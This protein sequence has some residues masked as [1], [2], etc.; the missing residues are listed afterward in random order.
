[1]PGLYRMLQ[2]LV[3]AAFVA[4]SARPLSFFQAAIEI[5]AARTIRITFMKWVASVQDAWPIV[6]DHPEDDGENVSGGF[7]NLGR[8]GLSQKNVPYR[9]A[10]TAVSI[11]RIGYIG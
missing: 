2:P 8:R 3:A 7:L 5:S 11:Q 6:V 9:S 4:M 1:M 10:A